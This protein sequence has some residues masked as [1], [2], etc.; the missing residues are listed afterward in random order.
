[1]KAF[2]YAILMGLFLSIIVYLFGAFYS[3]SFNSCNW[4]VSTRATIT[5]IIGFVF[6]IG[7]IMG[8]MIYG[9]D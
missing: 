4:E 9:E 5:V 2:I 7:L 3:C 8:M 1:M 6:I